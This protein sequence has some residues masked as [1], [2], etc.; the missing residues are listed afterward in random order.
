MPTS[1]RS[2]NQLT[3]GLVLCCIAL[4]AFVGL[5]CLCDGDG[6]LGVTPCLA[7][8]PTFE[9]AELS[10]ELPPMPR[11][12]PSMPVAAPYPCT[13]CRLAVVPGGLCLLD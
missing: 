1:R 7:D 12:R 5:A 8:T 2:V 9:P 3:W 11:L 4:A 10:R 13:P 6:D